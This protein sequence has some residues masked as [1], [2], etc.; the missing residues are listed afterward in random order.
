M[1]RYVKE[2]ASDFRKWYE[3]QCKENPEILPAGFLRQVNK[4][5]FNCGIGLITNREASESILTQWRMCEDYIAKHEG[6]FAIA[7]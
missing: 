4:I 7:L 1:K 6:Q 5:E 3:K 2:L